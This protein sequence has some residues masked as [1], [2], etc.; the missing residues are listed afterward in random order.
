[1]VP[2][3]S[4]Y[5]RLD[6]WPPTCEVGLA[7]SLFHSPLM[8]SKSRQAKAL[9]QSWPL[10]TLELMSVHESFFG[11]EEVPSPPHT[12]A[13]ALS[14]FRAAFSKR[15]LCCSYCLSENRSPSRFLRASS[16]SRASVR[17]SNPWCERSTSIS[18]R[19]SSLGSSPD[20]KYAKPSVEY[21]LLLVEYGVF[22]QCIGRYL[23]CTST[24]KNTRQNTYV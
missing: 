15:F 1:M 7:R 19:T 10:P 16:V 3:T 20:E 6:S 14:S 11:A 23:G 22:T 2:S 21:E 8:I 4:Q 24:I 5:L 12:L 9:S 17:L 13:A 18:H